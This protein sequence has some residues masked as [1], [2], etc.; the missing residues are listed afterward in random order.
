MESKMNGEE[1]WKQWLDMQPG[2]YEM[3][4]R[5]ERIFKQWNNDWGVFHY[6]GNI[7]AQTERVFITNKNIWMVILLFSCIKH[8]DH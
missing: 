1:N 5:I 2:E 3:M 7:S 4:E 8:C 6:M